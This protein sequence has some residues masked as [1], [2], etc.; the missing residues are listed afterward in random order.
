V[1]RVLA[2]RRELRHHLC[3]GTAACG[4]GP[5]RWQR[6]DRERGTG[7]RVAMLVDTD[8]GCGA[9]KAALG[10]KHQ[11]AGTAVELFFAPLVEKAVEAW[12]RQLDLTITEV[13][14]LRARAKLSEHV[15]EIG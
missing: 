3:A 7:Q 1:H 15:L 5:V 10:P 12:Q 8:S 6:P 9:A 14:R 2:S 11:I 13:D 4:I